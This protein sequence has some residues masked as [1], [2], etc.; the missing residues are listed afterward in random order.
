MLEGMLKVRATIENNLAV[1]QKTKH[2]TQPFYYHKYIQRNWQQV[3]K[4]Y[5][6]V[7]VHCSIIRNSQ[8]VETTRA[9]INKWMAKWNV[10]YIQW[11]IIQ[12]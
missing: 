3:L 4:Q 2:I 5:L 10:V 8:K 12:P 11:I 9:S 7:N 1:S 6:H